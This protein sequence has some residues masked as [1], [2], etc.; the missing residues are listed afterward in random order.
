MKS[1]RTLACIPSAYKIRISCKMRGDS[2]A[3]KLAL[4]LLLLT[5]ILLL[6]GQT[7]LR[8]S[9]VLASKFAVSRA[10][11]QD[12]N[13]RVVNV[14]SYRSRFLTEKVFETFTQQSKIKVRLVSAKNGLV[15]R[16]VQEG[17][18]SP[19]DLLISNDGT[20]LEQAKSQGITSAI[21]DNTFAG[22]QLP[23]HL[24]DKDRHWF[25]LTRRARILYV[26]KNRLGNDQIR[27]YEDLSLPQWKGRIC[28]RSFSHDYNLDLL[29]AILVHNG[30]R[31]TKKWLYGLRDNLARKPQGNDRAQ[32]RAISEGLCDVAIGNSYYYGIMLAD[33]KQRNW[34][35]NV[36]P[37]FPN[38]NDYGTHMNLTGTALIDSAPNRTEALQLMSFLLSFEAQS[39]FSQ[40]NYEYPALDGVPPAA[41]L[42]KWGVF[43]QDV[44]SPTRIA[45]NRRKAIE[46]VHE[47]DFNR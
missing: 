21:K 11:A 26:A 34:T 17:H 4:K 32:I 29:S 14:Y 46:L 28:T 47:V 30:T 12:A 27:R 13:E 2:F 25:A 38:Q 20:R 36:T 43:K 42:Q 16:I 3:G 1:T 19:A 24:R 39:M 45:K 33:S 15:E 6:A 8:A 10:V 7:H 5:F 22:N 40:L 37:I 35:E 31:K 41:L 18:S 23:V 44:L 9:L